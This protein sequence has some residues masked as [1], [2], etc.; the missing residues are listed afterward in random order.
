M[1]ISIKTRVNKNYQVIF[2]KFNLDLFKKLKPPFVKLNIERFDGCKKGD[3]VH[4]EINILG[5]KQKW[6][7]L[8]TSQF[9]GDY[10]IYFIDEGQNIP[11][12]LKKWKHIHRIQKIN[13]LD[14]Y[15]VDDIEYSCENILIDVLIYPFLYLVFF[16]RIPIYKRELS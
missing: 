9:R 6:V 5:Q 11:A 10:E 14:S 3:E 4:L 16:C 13:E 2:P 7:S 12:P 1:K 8:I 15:I